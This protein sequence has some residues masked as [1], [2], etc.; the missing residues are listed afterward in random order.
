[1]DNNMNNDF[2][3]I[4]PDS[5]LPP[6]RTDPQKWLDFLD[7][8][9]SLEERRQM[10]EEIAQ[11]DFLKDALDGL[12]PASGQEDLGSVMKELNKNLQRSL[13]PKKSRKKHRPIGDQ[14]WIWVTIVLLLG[15]CL[16]GYY[17]FA[18]FSMHR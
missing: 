11:S 5:S 7:G 2:N 18:H 4:N 12:Y 1:M 3:D 8:K 6:A 14:L 13:S 15:I 16:L 9:L 10:E 17:F